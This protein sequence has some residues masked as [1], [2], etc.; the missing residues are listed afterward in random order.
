MHLAGEIIGE[1]VEREEQ[2]IGN[3]SAETRLAS[4]TDGG[5]VALRDGQRGVAN[6]PDGR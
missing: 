2:W 1:T 3:E 5:C 4:A 6:E